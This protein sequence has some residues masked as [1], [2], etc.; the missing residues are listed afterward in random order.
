MTAFLFLQTFEG[1]TPAPMPHAPLMARLAQAGALGQGAGDMEVALPAEAMAATCTVVGNADDGIACIG[2]E[3]PRF[4]G[5]LRELVWDCMVQFGCA[6]FD[7]TLATVCT[8]AQGKDS[9]PAGL[10]QACLPGVRQIASAQQLWPG[11]FEIAQAAPPR[12][13]LRY[14]NPNPHGPG[15][16]M[17][18]H[19]SQDMGE[20]YIEIAMRPQAC[21]AATLRVLRNVELRVDA[22]LSANPGHAAVYRYS[23]QETALLVLESPPLGA[24]ANRYTTASPAPGASRPDGF[25]ADRAVFASEDAQASQF[26]AYA[27]DKYGVSLDMGAPD[28]GALAT[29]LDKAHAACREQRE[30]SGAGG[31]FNSSAANSWARLA[32]AFLGHF[33]VQ[34]IGAQWGYV[35]RGQHRLL[36]VRTHGGMLVCPHHLVLDHLINGPADGILRTVRALLRDAAGSGPRGE[37][38]VCQV[39]VL[40]EQLRGLR[41]FSGG[42]GLPFADLLARDRLDF[43]LAS[44]AHLDRYL[45][46]LAQRLGELPDEALSEAILCAGAYLGETVRSNAAA[47]SDWQW[48][49]YDHAAVRDPGF[50]VARPRETTMLAILDGPQQ[51]AYPFAHVA[52]LIGEGPGGASAQAFARQLCGGVQEA[53]PARPSAP[54]PARADRQGSPDET[55]EDAAERAARHAEWSEQMRRDDQFFETAGSRFALG[56]LALTM[57]MLFYAAKS[58]MAAFSVDAAALGLVKRML[59]GAWVLAPCLLL[60][61]YSIKTARQFLPQSAMLIASMF[62]AAFGGGAYYVNLA[63]VAG[64]A[65]LKVFMWVP[66]AQFVWIAGWTALMRR[67]IHDD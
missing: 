34:H 63:P 64:A 35:A 22:A 20:L 12:P 31:A 54:P 4:D 60:A 7:D 61:V 3:R 25:V 52:A 48:I 18:D 62:L 53:A 49:T 15:L 38:L 29:L 11:D 66:L 55:E 10:A 41:P 9:L 24:L 1:G 46:Q 23:D 27:R 14:P 59:Y 8:T 39:P 50:A 30:G 21:N 58:A 2:F 28:I 16:Q 56:I 57:L 67:Y 45:A 47:A 42:P 6:V 43:S 32:G 26:I 51:M 44:L 33:V 65:N 13:A 37:D 17:F 40:C 36:A 5:P 19:A